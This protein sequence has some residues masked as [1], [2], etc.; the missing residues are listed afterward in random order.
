M[1]ITISNMLAADQPALQQLFLAVRQ[2]SFTWLNTAAYQLTDFDEQTKDEWILLAKNATEIVGF[3]AVWLRESFIHHLFVKTSC[4]GM[5]IGTLLLNEVKRKLT[6]PIT[7]KC[8]TQNKAAIHFYK[9]NGFKE[10]ESGVSADGPFLVFEYEA[11]EQE[12]DQ[13]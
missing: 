11:L 8:L 10:K 9:S 2:Q 7:L 1:N 4:Q 12:Q 5:G 6:D 3:I 13:L